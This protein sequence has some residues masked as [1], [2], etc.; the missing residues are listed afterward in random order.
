MDI[1][2]T[3]ELAHGHDH[4]HDEDPGAS[5]T[6]CADHGAEEQQRTVI[7]RLVGTLLGGALVVNAYIADFAFPD[8]HGIGSIS[9]FFGAILLSIPLMVHAIRHLKRGEMNMEALACLAIVACFALEDYKTAGLLAFFLWMAE[10]IQNRTALGARAAIEHLLRLAPTVANVIQEDGSEVEVSVADLHVAQRVRVRPGDNVPV[11]GV[12]ITGETTI[13]EASVTGESF[14]A[15]KGPGAQ[16]F[17]GT[18]NL[19]GSI[20]VEVTRVGEDTTLGQVQHLIHQA[21]AS[22]TPVMR[23]I[24]Q[25]SRYYTPAMVMIVLLILFFTREMDR[26]IA[27]LVIVCPCAFILATP[28]AMVAALSCAARLG[29]LVKNVGDLEAAGN[30]NAIVFDKTGT[31]TT[32]QLVVTRLVPVGGVDGADLLRLAASVES[33][34]SHPVARA[35]VDVAKEANLDLAEVEGLAETPG[36]GVGG[37]VEGKVVLVGRENWLR[38]QGVDMAP[39]DAHTEKDEALSSVVVA[40]DGVCLGWIGLEDQTRPQAKNATAGLR[41]LGM[42]RMVLLTGDKWAVARKVSQELGCTDVEAECLPERKLELVEELKSQGYMVGVVGDGVNDAPALAAGDIGIAMGAAGSDVALN[43]AT[44]ALLNNDLERL[45]FLVSLSRR[46]R[47]V[48]NEN[49]LF[50][51]CFMVGGLV[52]AGMG[53]MTPVLAAFLHNV[54]SFIVIFNSAR[55][56]RLGEHFSPHAG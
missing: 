25:Y 6:C 13:D 54:G 2:A 32:G 14:P 23:L 52:L 9:A 24:D 49:L 15:D 38:E 40:V 27:A 35:V 20:E 41:E 28:T 55:L 4:G 30:L 10:L 3:N 1:A 21:E 44:I 33:H 36:K 48:V 45:P 19:T 5:M 39:Y 53:L 51:F 50:G 16:V 22:K 47:W 11:D 26:A 18:S 37:M 43:S 34:S 17:A 31:L 12:I 7:L 56:V 46:C 29:I 42:R 8:S